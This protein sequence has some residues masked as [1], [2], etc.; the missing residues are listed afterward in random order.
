MSDIKLEAQDYDRF[1]S[2]SEKAAHEAA[3]V[4]NDA[5]VAA[6]NK[7]IG[8]K[9]EKA[10]AGTFVDLTPHPFARRMVGETRMSACGSPAAMCMDAGGSQIGAETMK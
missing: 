7:Q 3:I 8:R 10:V 5:F 9:R 2:H 1:L 6:M 4:S